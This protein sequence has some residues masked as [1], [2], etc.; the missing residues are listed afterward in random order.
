MSA[1]RSMVLDC[2]TQEINT[3]LTKLCPHAS[4]PSKLK[5]KQTK[6]QSGSQGKPVQLG[7][8]YCCTA[9]TRRKRSRSGEATVRYRVLNGMCPLSRVPVYRLT[10]KGC[11]S[12]KIPEISSRGL[13]Q[14]AGWYWK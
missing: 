14:R 1:S 5:V 2:Y 12:C 10:K 11:R 6:K 3:I 13:R 9:Y 4:D 7:T 8:R